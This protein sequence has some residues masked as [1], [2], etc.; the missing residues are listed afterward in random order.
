MTMHKT[1]AGCRQT[2][3]T[4]CGRRRQ[5]L[6]SAMVAATVVVLPLVSVPTAAHAAVLAAGTW[7]ATVPQLPDTA[8]PPVTVELAA[9]TGSD[10]TIY[11]IGGRY[12][13]TVYTLAPGASQ[14]TSGPA[15]PVAT[16]GLAAATGSDGTIY[17]I[18][19]Y[20]SAGATNAVYALPEGQSTWLTQANGVPQLPT[21]AKWL[22]ATT[23]T[24]GTIYAIGGNDDNGDTTHVYALAP[25]GSSWKSLAA[26]PSATDEL[27][28]ATGTDGTVYAIGGLNG[29]YDTG[30]VEAYHPTTDTWSAVASLPTPTEGLAAVAGTDG[31]IYAL[32]G[33]RSDAA[34]VYDPRNGMW[35]AIG[36]MPAV[37]GSL[38][39]ALGPGG[40]VY[41]IGGYDSSEHS[42]TQVAAYAPSRTIASSQL[43]LTFDGTDPER[44]THL[45]WAPS[46]STNYVAEGGGSCTGSSDPQEYFGQAYGDAGDFVIRGQSGSWTS[47]GSTATISSV[48]NPS[49]GGTTTTVSTGYVIEDTSA[50]QNEVQV[51]RTFHFGTTAATTGSLRAYVPRLPISV[52]SSVLYPSSTSGS[53]T[54]TGTSAD[55]TIVSDWD[56]KKGWFADDNGAGTG[57]LVLRDPGDALVGSLVVDNDMNSASNN[58]D[59]VVAQPAGGWVGDQTETEYLCFYSPSTWSS[60]DRNAGALPAGCGAFG[61]PS[62][63][64]LPTAPVYGNTFTPTVAAAGDGATSVT[65]GTTSVCTVTGTV[66][67]FVGVGEC[68][69]TAHISAGTN[70]IAASG[71]EQS[72]EVGKATPT[73]PSI[74]N[75]PGSPVSGG[76]FVPQ[77]TT[78]GDGTTSVTSSSPSCTVAPSTGAVSFVAVGECVLTAHVAAG[79]HYT[80]SDGDS[81]SLDVG[82][83]AP[84]PAP[85]APAGQSITFSTPGGAVV[86][87]PDVPLHATSTSGL[88]VS[89][90]TT[91]PLVC[92]ITAAGLLHAVAPGLCTVT[93]SQ[94]GGGAYL[95]ATPVTVALTIAGFTPAGPMRI[96]DTRTGLGAPKSPVGPA[97][98]IT[99]TVPH[100]PASV[101]AVVLNLTGTGLTGAGTTYV[102]ACPAAQ[103]LSSCM[104]TSVL[105]IA[106]GGTAA[107]EVTVPVGPDGK[108]TLYNHAGHVDL[109]ADLAGYLT[110]V[111]TSAGPTRVLDTRTSARIPAG[112]VGPGETVSVSF[113]SMPVGTTGIVMDL[114]GTGLTGAHAT[115]ISACPAA[116]ALTSCKATSAL[117]VTGGDTASNEVTIPV[118]PDGRITLYNN[119][120]SISLAADLAG[121]LT[122]GYTAAGP[123]R[124]LDTRSGTGAAASAVGPAGTLTVTIP[125]LPPGT[126]AV[127]L[128]LTGTNLTGAPQTFVSA[129]PAAEARTSCAAT[130]ALNVIA[131]QDVANEITVPVGTD[132]KITLYNNAGHIDLVADLT[133]YLS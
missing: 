109:V 132:G 113:P 122:G 89:Y 5:R 29:S 115:Y 128:N 17:A 67:N 31:R 58:S 23:G 108:I 65:S 8:T 111:F 37:A 49:C 19:G 70:G 103:P 60:D 39:A 127:A 101:S 34:Y 119:A 85:S 100:L 18:G 71:G 112:Q 76:T 28:A 131:G 51:T 11:A 88:P 35:T 68:T 110:G 124:V 36:P 57:M 10:G 4:G 97:S 50:Y 15:L 92:T 24:D 38:G 30:A 81:Q 26:L 47:T 7:T 130:S 1:T 98:T 86:G 105:N 117:N 3:P 114:T 121:Y 133:G 83:A 118:G 82:P 54:S 56:A 42:T 20:T 75:L 40:T 99:L 125:D 32:G 126:T 95:A 6:G 43:S 14:W 84:P 59:I 87:Q 41:S 62:I 13:A 2:T 80:G 27:A 61:P 96:L 107:N 44:V 94:S 102:S 25:G 16:A 74:T 73:K 93:A 46:G 45:T 90:S 78:T 123:V 106:A 55:G 129:C 48:G 120:G 21:A 64:N 52:Y 63:T 66:V 77:V 91:T 104:A 72:F 9:T 53:V 116:E 33:D 22:A 79:P 12:S 69:L